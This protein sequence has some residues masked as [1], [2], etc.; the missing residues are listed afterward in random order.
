MFDNLQTSEKNISRNLY[1]FFAKWTV[2]HVFSYLLQ[3]WHPMMLLM[4][5]TTDPSMFHLSKKLC[6]V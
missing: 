3:V 2:F 5:S 6:L 1:S 4:V